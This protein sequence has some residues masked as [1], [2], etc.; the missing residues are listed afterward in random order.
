MGVRILDSVWSLHAHRP[1]L[2]LVLRWPCQRPA[3]LCRQTGAGIDRPVA[4]RHRG[5]RGGLAGDM[6]GGR[7]EPQQRHGFARSQHSRL[8]RRDRRRSCDA[9]PRPRLHRGAAAAGGLGLALDEIGRARSAPAASRALD[10]RRRR[11]HRGRERH[12]GDRSLAAAE[13]PWRRG[14]RRHSGRRPGHHRDGERP[15]RRRL[16][17]RLR[18]RGDSQPERRLRAWV[19]RTNRIATSRRI[20]TTTSPEGEKPSSSP[21]GTSRTM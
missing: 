11:R 15:C 8:A 3:E 6:V 17:H 18:G 14:R 10:H 4:A 21:I 16:G 13:R 7:S 9:D 1:P 19:F 12:A 5:S 2:L 20:S